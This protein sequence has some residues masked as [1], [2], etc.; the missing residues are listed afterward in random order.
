M[1]A[2]EI[3]SIKWVDIQITI[4]SVM[5]QTPGII[6]ESGFINMQNV[7]NLSQSVYS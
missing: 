7:R 4:R 3:L 1:T 2:I 6:A 5:D